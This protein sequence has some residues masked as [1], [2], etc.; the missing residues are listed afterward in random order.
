MIKFFSII[1]DCR[2][3]NYKLSIDEKTANITLLE[4][5]IKNM[6]E[7]HEKGGHSEEMQI[8]NLEEQMNN[9]KAEREQLKQMIINLTS[10]VR[11][12]Y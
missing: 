7:T 12:I 3:T 5:L 6:K 8:N 1:T 9:M 10:H 2:E 4:Y 11:S